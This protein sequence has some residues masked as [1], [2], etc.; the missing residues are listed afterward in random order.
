SMKL[1]NLTILA[2]VAIASAN[3]GPPQTC[4]QCRVAPDKNHCDMTTSCTYVWGHNAPGPAPYY[5]ACH[6]GCAKD[7]TNAEIQ[8]RL[9]W[10][11]SNGDPSQ[12]GRVFVKPGVECNTLCD[13]WYLGKDW[14]KEVAEKPACM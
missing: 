7:A 3:G 5:C 4:E 9:P 8:W 14:C 6:V 13:E 2:F 10:F 11:G 1:I 12:Q